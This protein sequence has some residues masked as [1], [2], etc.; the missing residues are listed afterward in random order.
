MS[1]SCTATSG[2]VVNQGFVSYDGDGDGSNE[3]SAPTD[4]PAGAGAA[5]PTA[6]AVA[7]APGETMPVPALDRFAMLLLIGALFTLAWRSRR[8]TRG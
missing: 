4:D 3:S 8:Q 1:D 7:A 2:T 5:D 6:F